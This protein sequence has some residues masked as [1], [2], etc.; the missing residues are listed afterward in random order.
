MVARR[1]HSP[2]IH[3]FPKAFHRIRHC[4]QLANGGTDRAEKP[5]RL[6]APPLRRPHKPDSHPRLLIGLPPL[7]VSWRLSNAGPQFFVRVASANRVGIRNPPQNQPFSELKCSPFS[8]PRP[9][10]GSGSA[11]RLH[12]LAWA[13]WTASTWTVKDSGMSTIMSKQLAASRHLLHSETQQ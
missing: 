6:A 9:Y 4:G 11:S 12:F 1:V 5:A 10:G 2:L 8:S 7:A 13:N 3:L